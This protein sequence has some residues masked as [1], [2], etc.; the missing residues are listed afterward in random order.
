VKRTRTH[1]GFGE[2][3]L[4][5]VVAELDVPVVVD[6]HIGGLQEPVYDVVLVQVFQAEDDLPRVLGDHLFVLDRT[7]L[8]QRVLYKSTED[9]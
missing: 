9:K 3:E 6:E 1:Y 8:D 4:K 2:E 5:A 7:Q